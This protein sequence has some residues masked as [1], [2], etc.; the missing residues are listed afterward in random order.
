MRKRTE[1]D[2]G[3]LPLIDGLIEEF[4]NITLVELSIILEKEKL[5]YEGY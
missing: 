4:G 2:L 1:R 5:E 3:F